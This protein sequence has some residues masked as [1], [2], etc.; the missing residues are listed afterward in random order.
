MKVKVKVWTLVIAPLTWVRL[1]TMQQRFTILKVA[2][3]WHE[4]MVPQRA[5]RHPLPAYGQWTHGAASSHSVAPISH[6]R[7]SP[8]SRSY[9][10]F[11]VPL[12]VEGWVGLSTQYRLATCSRL[13]AVDQVWVATSRLRVRYSIPPHH[14]SVLSVNC[15]SFYTRLHEIRWVY[16]LYLQ[17]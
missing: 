17:N 9:Y 16:S 13:L 6:T 1:V 2:A 5:C 7:P 11:P 12:R 15:I 3:D 8:R 4:P 14:C 10:L